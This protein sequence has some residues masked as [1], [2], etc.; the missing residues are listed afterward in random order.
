MSCKEPQLQ[1]TLSNARLM[2]SVDVLSTAYNIEDLTYRSSDVETDFSPSV[3]AITGG[4]STTAGSATTKRPR[5]R[6]QQPRPAKQ[7]QQGAA[8]FQNSTTAASRSSAVE[9]NREPKVGNTVCLP[10]LR[11]SG[12]CLATPFGHAHVQGR[13]IPVWMH[14]KEDRSAL[15]RLPRKWHYF[16]YRNH[17]YII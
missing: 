12:L 4:E 6:P 15:H 1:I 10:H 9:T 11:A 3:Q 13:K 2:F 5:K 8:P 14:S 17:V 16:L 7:A